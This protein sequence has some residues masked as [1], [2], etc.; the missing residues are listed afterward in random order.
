MAQASVKQVCKAV[1]LQQTGV[2]HHCLLTLTTMVKRPF[3]S[4]GI[5]KRP[6]DLDYIRFASDLKN[7]G[8]DKTDKYDEDA[9][10]AMPDGSSHPFCLKAMENYRSGMLARIGARQ[11]LKGYFNGAAYADLDADGNPDL[12]INCLNA[13]AVILKNNAPKKHTASIS[14]HSDSTNI[15]ASAPRPICLQEMACNT[16]S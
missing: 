4:S 8:M 12:I 6:V 16:S 3:I 10:N 2:G 11:K 7:K 5:V 13:P 14:F 9:I 15:L 1:W